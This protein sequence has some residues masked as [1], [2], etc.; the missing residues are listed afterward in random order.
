[1]NRKATFVD[2]KLNLK[3][4]NYSFRKYRILEIIH[5]LPYLDSLEIKNQLIKI[6]GIDRTTF[7]KWLNMSI[8]DKSEIPSLK[9]AII[10]KALNS[11]IEDLFNI[12]IP[13]I[14]NFQPARQEKNKLQI[15]SGLVI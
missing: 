6:L 1:M 14:E 9:L 2:S 15:N 13:S 10:A 11:S 3:N 4:Q 7:S 5:N 8:S 12:Q